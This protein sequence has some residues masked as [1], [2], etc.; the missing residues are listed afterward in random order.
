[1]YCSSAMCPK[2]P[3]L[4]LDMHVIN[5]PVECSLQNSALVLSFDCLVGKSNWCNI[6]RV[7]QHVMWIGD[8]CDHFWLY[9]LNNWIAG[10]RQALSPG[11]AFEL[12][13]QVRQHRTSSHGIDG[14]W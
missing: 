11:E 7:F 1:M 13:P 12:L 4:D 6:L 14:W 8:A 10:K 9:C 5:H 2:H 3:L